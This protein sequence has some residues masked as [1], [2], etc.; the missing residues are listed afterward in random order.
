MIKINKKQNGS[1]LLELLIAISLLCIIVFM[2]ANAVFLS[3]KSNEASRDRDVGSTLANESLEAV[4]AVTEENWQN[5]YSLSKDGTHY[6]VIQRE[7]KWVVESVGNATDEN[8]TFNNKIY[9]RYIIIENV[10][11]D[12][13]YKIET[14]YNA[15]KDDPST[16]KVSVVVISPTGDETLISGYFFR[17][18]N[19]ICNQSNWVTGGSGNEAKG[20]S[21]TTFYDVKDETIDNEGGVLKLQ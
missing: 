10:S 5:I 21:S 15:L 19:L 18:K 20:C 16:Q 6:I 3:M 4:R 7:G 12:T 14:A 13:D 17:W 9:R 8:I 2:G 1:L 11:R